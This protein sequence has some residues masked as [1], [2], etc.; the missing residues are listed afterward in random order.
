MKQSGDGLV[1]SVG[2]AAVSFFQLGMLIPEVPVSG[3][4]V[5]YG[6]VANSCLGKATGEKKGAP[7]LI[8]VLPAEAVEFFS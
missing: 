2:I 1:D 7:E 4:G 5:I 3:C 8:G 6:D